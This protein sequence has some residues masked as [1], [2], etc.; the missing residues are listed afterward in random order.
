[1]EHEKGE[2]EEEKEAGRL[3]R[4]AFCRRGAQATFVIC[5]MMQ[6]NLLLLFFFSSHPDHP[7]KGKTFLS[8]IQ[9]FNKINFLCNYKDLNAQSYATVLKTL[10]I[11]YMRKKLKYLSTES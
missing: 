2:K 3:C 11:N 7:I 9:L 6:F 10:K 4:A 8:A 1:M 5:M